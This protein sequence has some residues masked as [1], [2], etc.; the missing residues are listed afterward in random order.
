MLICSP[1]SN[2]PEVAVALAVAA[3]VHGIYVHNA[4]LRGEHRGFVFGQKTANE[5]V[6]W[7]GARGNLVVVAPEDF[8]ADPVAAEIQKARLPWR[9]AMGP[10]A[11]IDALRAQ[12][13]GNPLVHR[14]QVYYCGDGEAVNRELISSDMRAAAL[15]DRDRIVQASLQLN[16]TDLAIEPQR[17]DRRWLYGTVDERIAESTTRVLGPVGKI[18]AKLDFGSEGPGGL[19]IEG[20]F[21][22]PEARGRGLAAKLVAS[23]IAEASSRVGLHVGEQNIAARRAYERAGM[24]QVDRCRLLLLG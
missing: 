21:T 6:C 18:D 3:S 17:V 11:I 8:P 9:I 14:D 2:E 4:L 1:L 23:C 22:F 16:H 15:G 20:V 24:S 19:V 10:A 7:F 13:A 12:C 5:G